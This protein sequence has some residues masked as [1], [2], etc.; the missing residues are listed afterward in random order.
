ML[1]PIDINETRMYSLEGDS[2]EPKTIFI[3]GFFDE[4]LR[5]YVFKKMQKDPHDPDALNEI[6][7][8]GLKG[9]EN[10]NG[11]ECKLVPTTNLAIDAK[12]RQALATESLAL[13]YPVWIS[14]L[15]SQIF[16]MN[17]LGGK[18]EKN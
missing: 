14:E 7:R 10:L 12:S 13:L 5:N 9:W 16:E 15:A 2:S 1:I 3:L 17:I 4:V 6:V 18:K 11:R 8:Y